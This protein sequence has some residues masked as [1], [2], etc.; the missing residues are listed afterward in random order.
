[1]RTQ[2]ILF[3][4]FLL[5]ALAAGPSAA[6][7]AQSSAPTTPPAS[8][9]ID[10]PALAEYVAG[11]LG[12]YVLVDVRSREEYSSGHIP[13]AINIPYTEIA[14]SPPTTDSQALIILYCSSGNR[15]NAARA[16]LTRIGYTRVVNFGS[17]SQWT[18]EVESEK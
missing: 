8:L 14:L 5:W 6:L 3:F 17:L 16:A 10:A 2:R 12:A 1:M 4:G 18:G 15:A 9:K 7:F 11:H 13:T